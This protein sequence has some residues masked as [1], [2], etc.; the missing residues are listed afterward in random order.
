MKIYTKQGDNG[1]TSLCGPER[2]FKD[3]LRIR[4]YGIVDELNS[5][6]GWCR[7]IIENNEVNNAIAKVQKDLFVLGTDLATP[8]SGKNTLIKK[9]DVSSL[10]KIL[11]HFDDKLPPLKQFILPSGSELACRLHI[12]RTICRRAERR[13]VS[14][15]NKVEINQDIAPY[16]NRLSDLLFVMARFANCELN[17]IPEETV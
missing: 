15:K 7:V 13:V 11:D 6:L 1:H 14:L 10:E 16:L 12:A 9:Q 5:V 3:D 17:S 8:G 2:A 4:A